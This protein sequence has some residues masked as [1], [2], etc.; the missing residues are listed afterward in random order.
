[1]TTT[2]SKRQPRPGRFGRLKD[3]ATSYA[4]VSPF[5]ILFGVFWL[6][7]IGLSLALSFAEWKGADGASFVGLANYRH[8][9]VDSSFHRALAHTFWL[10]ITVIPVLTFG[11]LAVAWFLESKLVRLKT[12]LRT[13]LFLPVLPS[14][15]VV[16]VIFLLLLDPEYG[17]PI[18]ALEALGLGSVNIKTDEAA[19]IPI[20]ALTT[21]WRWFGYHVIIQLAGLQAL[22]RALLES[23]QVDGASPRQIFFRIV[24]PMSRPLLLFGGVMST[25]GVLNLFDTAYML[26]GVQ[27]GPGESGLTLGTLLF[28]EAFSRFDLGY[29]SAIAYVLTAGALVASLIMLKV[30]HRGDE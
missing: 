13:V 9:F 2:A 30:G 23:A 24:C 3:L 16:G 10:L 21:I 7:A 6:F 28:R 25:I 1:M 5:V 17:L 14:L 11:A 26:Y 27:G 20:L 15:V 4:L 12:L 29:A 19:A 22:D 8:L 18:R